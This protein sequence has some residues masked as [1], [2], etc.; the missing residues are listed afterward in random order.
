M[1]RLLHL[2][3]YAKINY[4]LREYLPLSSSIEEGSRRCRLEFLAKTALSSNNGFKT[5]VA[6]H[7]CIVKRII[8]DQ[9]QWF[10]NFCDQTSL[11][12]SPPSTRQLY[13]PGQNAKP[14]SSFLAISYQD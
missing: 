6:I 12:G 13:W 9:R 8:G 3:Y 4:R 11:H 5:C 10:H 14:I 7:R 2:A 1:K